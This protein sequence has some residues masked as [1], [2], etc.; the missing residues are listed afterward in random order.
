MKLLV[1][2]LYFIGIIAIGIH[3]SKKNKTSKGF[4]LGGRKLNAITAALGAGAADMS[5]WVM[6]ALPG[7]VFLNGISEIWLPIGLTI[8][9]YLNWQFVA[10]RI[11][12]KTQKY[13]DS[14]TIAGYLSNRFD[15]KSGFL[16]VIVAIITAIFFI[17]YIASALV[18]LAFLIETYTP[19]DYLYCL[20]FS[21]AFVFIYTA[22]G[23]FTA[24]NKI[25][26]MQGL[27]MLF[28]LLL[29]PVTMLISSDNS[30]I[31][32]L[33]LNLD[34]FL[35]LDVIAIV[36]LLSWGLGYFG[37]PHILVRFM[38][39]DKSK[40]LNASKNICMSW[41]ILSLIGSF[42]IGLLGI[43]LFE[44]VDNINP[45][46]IF[47]LSADKLFPG[48]LS[49]FV[50]AAVLSAIMST[51]SAQLHATAC[52]L[53]EDIS[54]KIFGKFNKVWIA[55]IIMFIVVLI[56][57]AYASNPKS[58]ILGLV[59]LAWAGLGSAFGP[60]ILFSLYLKKMTKISALSGIITGGLTVVIWRLL[61][62]LGGV[63]ELFEIIPGFILSSLVIIL[64]HNISCKK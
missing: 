37:Q 54:P 29:V 43:L 17:I 7:A 32:A 3:S 14:V 45:E 47:L 49:G 21:G 12:V 52:S 50:L 10:R 6:M 62:P 42:C 28:A 20:I 51:I 44:N 13:G 46:T 61:K 36:S 19:Y 56:S 8:G 18:A 63:F 31:R 24:I 27:L 5:G 39:I 59:S 55:R 60:T 25:D 33:D 22:L 57:M 2:I 16:R 53:T 4:A 35:N 34:P 58:T 30:D 40:T 41:M 48:W 1:V 9:A 15:D 64:V 38:A 26:V 11:R 23:G